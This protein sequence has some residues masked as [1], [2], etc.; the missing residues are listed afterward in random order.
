MTLDL[1]LIR[2][3]QAEPEGS[4]VLAWFQVAFPGDP[5]TYSY[6]AIKLG[7]KWFI[8]GKY[9]AVGRDWN[10]LLDLLTRDGA[11]IVNAQLA[12]T[13]EDL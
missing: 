4:R 10:R 8:T 2:L 11:T 7:T 3:R 6:A 5:R 9:G 13:M 1:K 12:T